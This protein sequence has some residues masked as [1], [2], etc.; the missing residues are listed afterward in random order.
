MTNLHCS[1]A[2]GIDAAALFLSAH[3]NLETLHL[4]LANAHTRAAIVLRPRSLPSLR[5]LRSSKEIV[6]A[7]LECPCDA[8]RPLETIIGV[9]LTGSSWDGTFLANLKRYGSSV[10]RIEL[11]GW[12][13]MED[14]KRLVDC[15]PHLTWLDVG[16]K[17]VAS[18]TAIN[19]GKVAPLVHTNVVSLLY[20][21]AQFTRGEEV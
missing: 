13:E 20:I 14:I 19:S 18:G 1:S 6:N 10:K 2:A 8:P 21:C 12:R 7:V 16:K 4:D 11:A 3:P 17:I 5:E 15:V 9:K